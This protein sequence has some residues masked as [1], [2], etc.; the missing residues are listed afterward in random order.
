MS[1]VGAVGG[2]HPLDRQTISALLL[3]VKDEESFNEDP[4]DLSASQ[5][6][7]E[8]L[9]Q[10][11]KKRAVNVCFGLATTTAAVAR[12][13]LPSPVAQV[14]SSI[15]IGLGFS[16]TISSGLDKDELL[17]RS[18]MSSTALG[19]SMLLLLS[20]LYYIRNEDFQKFCV[21]AIIAQLGVTGEI[22]LRRLWREH[23]ATADHHAF[24]GVS[25]EKFKNLSILSKKKSYAL[26][27]V[28]SATCAVFSN[29]VT[30]DGFVR[31]ILDFLA[32][33]YGTQVVGGAF[34]DWI[35]KMV[36][37]T[38]KSGTEG[39]ITEKRGTRWRWA[40]NAALTISF[41]GLIFSNWVPLR[42]IGYAGGFE[43]FRRECIMTRMKEAPVVALVE[44]KPIPNTNPGKWRRVPPVLYALALTTF[45]VWQMVIGDLNA[46]IS[47]AAWMGGSL[48][49]G[50]TLMYV[51]RN[52]NPKIRNKTLDR[53]KVGV[54]SPSFLGVDPASLLAAGI[55]AI[56]LNSQVVG[57]QNSWAYTGVAATSYFSMGAVAVLD[58]GRTTSNEQGS[59]LTD[60]SMGLL[61]TA[62]ETTLNALAGRV[63]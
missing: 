14:V 27:V 39:T 59:V 44:F 62:G 6:E 53:L 32:K 2:Y 54:L 24:P 60:T 15:G 18:K 56:R 13:I 28:A 55:K 34:A 5:P 26:K 3:D 9:W 36:Q 57:A 23:G 47:M 4:V 30:Q 61:I 19:F 37:K 50:A 29:V 63:S 7:E 31:E 20:Q 40:K 22:V 46:T 8:S 11:L 16:A 51:N 25:G 17:E 12:G 49:A 35:N 1:T 43:Q 58:L 41:L 33:R 48:A 42:Y 10:K 52:W 38:N 21:S 45:G